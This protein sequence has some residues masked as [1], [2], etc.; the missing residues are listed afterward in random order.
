MIDEFQDAGGIDDPF[1]Q[2]GGVI[3][4]AVVLPEKEGID[5]KGSDCLTN[6]SHMK[7]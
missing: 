2:K 4:K 1:F 6:F 3:G 5:D 7:I